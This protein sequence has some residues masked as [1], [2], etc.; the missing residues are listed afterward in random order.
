VVPWPRGAT[1]SPGSYHVSVTARDHNSGTLLRRAHS[2]GV[3]TLT[4]LAPAPSPLQP[5]LEAA[6]PP[7][8]ALTPAQ[9]A[10]L[11]AVFP[12]AGPHSVGGP[13]NRFGAPRSG[14]VHQ[15]QDILT[16]EG[17]AIVAPLDGVV[18]GASYEA[19]GAGYYAV[20]HTG[21]GLDFMFAHCRSGSL[22]VTAGQAVSTGQ[23]LC[24]A[25]QTG[26]ATTP[27][28][29]FEIWIGGWQAPEGQPIDPLPY[30]QAWDHG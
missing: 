7:A 30:L 12:V 27:H 18:L 19:G 1:L 2:S 8:G 17:T 21:H 25:G 20:E 9:S 24:Q 22:L 16:A 28:L 3:A 15:G 23:P 14:H 4:V 11:G 29:H 10:A 5:P 13:E 6:T 26:D